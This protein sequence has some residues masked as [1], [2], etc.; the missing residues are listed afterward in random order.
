MTRFGKPRKRYL[1]GALHVCTT[2][3]VSTDRT[4]PQPATAL[5]YGE[6]YTQSYLHHGTMTLLAVLAIFSGKVIA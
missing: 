6:G 5:G 3:I 1:N 4:Q 2:N